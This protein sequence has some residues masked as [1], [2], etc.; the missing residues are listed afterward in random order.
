MAPCNHKRYS[1]GNLRDINCVPNIYGFTCVPV[2]WK[3]AI[4]V[5][6]ALQ[7]QTKKILNFW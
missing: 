2:I 1:G 6:M 5:S 3:S 7:G 4:V